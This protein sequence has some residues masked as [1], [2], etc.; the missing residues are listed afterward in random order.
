MLGNETVATICCERTKSPPFGIEGGSA[1]TPA[2][3][4][5]VDPDGVE[6][7]VNSKGSFVAPA[8]SL[9]V[10]EVPGSGGYGP[11][12]D[13]DPDSLRADLFDGY[14]TAEGASRDYPSVRQGSIRASRG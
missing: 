4:A 6:R 9:V 11:P 7:V 8:D 1:G 12:S 3:V 5:V 14:V 10:F 13:R 2:R